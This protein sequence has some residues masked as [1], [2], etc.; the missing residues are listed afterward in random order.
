MLVSY[1]GRSY[2]SFCFDLGGFFLWPFGKYILR[3]LGPLSYK[4]VANEGVPL[5][6]RRPESIARLTAEEMV[7]G[8]FSHCMHFPAT[9]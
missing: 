1:F 9:P 2:A 7:S 5:L 4:E 8:L 6:G 3:E